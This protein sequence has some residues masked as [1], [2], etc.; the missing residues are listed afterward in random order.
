[1]QVD[2]HIVVVRVL[3]LCSVVPLVAT[4][5]RN[6]WRVTA[7][8]SIY[9]VCSHKLWC[10][11]LPKLRGVKNFLKYSKTDFRSFPCPLIP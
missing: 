8:T 1:M 3:T 2:V 9:R 4:C 11:A 10:T 7:A 5:R 6:T